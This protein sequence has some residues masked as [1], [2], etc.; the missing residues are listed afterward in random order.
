VALIGATRTKSGLCVRCVLDEAK[1]IK[2]LE[3][4]EKDFS[5]ISLTPDDFHGEWNYTIN[6]NK[7]KL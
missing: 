4:S 7:H 6:P 5:S 2:G 3:V 1:Y